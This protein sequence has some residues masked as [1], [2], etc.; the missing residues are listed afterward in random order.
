MFW[1]SR[2]ADSS[3]QQPAAPAEKSPSPE[4]VDIPVEL[5]VDRTAVSFM[6]FPHPGPLVIAGTTTL[7]HQC[8]AGRDWM[9]VRT[10]EGIFIRCRCTHTWPEPRMASQ[11]F[12]D[13]MGPVTGVAED[14]DQ[15]QRS[16][17][18]DGAFSGAY[19]T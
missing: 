16:M 18:Y 11:Q 2:K 17:G 15:A 13:L 12:D 8:G 1:R 4:S 3:E 10:A 9:V 5:R 6:A 14:F 19:L 7:C